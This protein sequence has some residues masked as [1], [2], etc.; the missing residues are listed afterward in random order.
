MHC[1]LCDWLVGVMMQ[2]LSICLQSVS[3]TSPDA[4]K[5]KLPT[6]FYDAF[7]VLGDHIFTGVIRSNEVQY[8]SKSESNR[9][10]FCLSKKILK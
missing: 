6:S 2:K 7:P 5:L 10:C 4:V 8:L 3:E 1:S 9:E